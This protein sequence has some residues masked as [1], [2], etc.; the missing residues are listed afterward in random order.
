M[1]CP[2]LKII[3][4]CCT[5]T[6]IFFQ[7]ILERRAVLWT[8][9]TTH[10]RISMVGGHGSDITLFS[11]LQIQ[12]VSKVTLWLLCWHHSCNL[13]EFVVCFFFPK[14]ESVDFASPIEDEIWCNVSMW[15]STAEISHQSCKRRIIST[16]HSSSL[17]ARAETTEWV[18]KVVGIN[19]DSFAA[20]IL[21][22]IKLWTCWLDKLP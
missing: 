16:P 9:C 20:Y 1:L 8:L 5:G 21:P 13:W 7:N 19:Y 22:N 14:F 17:V 12:A 18:Q 3:N 4:L 11:Y 10:T 2:I 15:Q 6:K